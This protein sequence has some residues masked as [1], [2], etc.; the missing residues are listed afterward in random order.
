MRI[1]SIN[2][3]DIPPLHRFVV[4]DLSDLIVL[5]GPN[6]VGKTR[7]IQHFLQY[8]QN[9]RVQDRM[10]MVLE[11]TCK[12]ESEKWGK[13]TLDT[14]R[15]E[16]ALLVKQT[17]KE[18]RRRRNWRSSVMYFE[19]DRSIQ[20]VQPYA[21]T[22]NIQDPDEEN[23]NWNS[24]FGGLRGRWQDTLHSI[25]RKIQSHVDRLGRRA[26]KLDSE[27]KTSMPLKL[28]D[29]LNPFRVAF[30][31]LL[32]PKELAEVDIR[33]QRLSYRVGNS[34]FNI[35]SLSSGEQEVVNIIF[36]FI[37]RKPSNSIV[38]FDEP[39]LHLH[40]ELSHKLIQT[41]RR[42]GENNQFI[43]CTHSS[44]II[45]AS[46]DSSVI[47][48]APPKE[49]HSNQAIPVSED[50]ETNQ[51][52][53]RLGQSVGII[54]LGKKI[55]LIEGGHSS[56]DKQLYGTIL[57]ERFPNLVLVPSSGKTQITSF[58]TVLD[59]VLR[60]SIWGVDFFMVCDRDAI[61]PKDKEAVEVKA[62]GRLRVLDRYHIEN[63]FLDES[64]LAQVFE[65]Q[66]G[67]TN[68]L[69]DPEKIR[70]KLI[71]LARPMVPY[72]LALYTAAHFRE[73]VGN[74]DMMPKGVDKSSVEEMIVLLKSK[75]SDE[76]ARVVEAVEDVKVDEFVADL[77]SKLNDSFRENTDY[78][79]KVIPGKRLLSKF[80]HAA[81]IPV[82]R[83]KRGYIKRAPGGKD[84]PFKSVIE[85]FDGFSKYS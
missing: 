35:D 56:L 78:W 18:N 80:A 68:W 7:L 43:F 17:L 49:D 48:L 8:F 33:E 66:V 72:T 82:D 44:D 54:A 39:E 20:K 63:F 51:A 15:Q 5:A 34:E 46:L 30:R 36:D 16:D 24:T 45:T 70:L 73:Q 79:K 69:R 38:V 2:A 3:K 32:A 76:S 40:P 14:S 11:A 85:I 50:D 23:I 62:G 42:A 59:A 53:R 1:R 58:S 22:W 75:A 71:E 83:L 10:S 21:F 60:H 13:G 26:I 61:A 19:S 67:D 28:K 29:P 47:F 27:G 84:S 25:F 12:E 37:L 65:D 77:T 4:Q 55:V 31:Q 81:S 52:L 57:E 64:V 6:G 41:L 74:I 9:P